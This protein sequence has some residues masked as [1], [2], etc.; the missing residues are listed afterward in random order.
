MNSSSD[1][2]IVQYMHGFIALMTD[3]ET[4]T[5]R[6]DSSGKLTSVRNMDFDKCIMDIMDV[7]TLGKAVYKFHCDY[8][9]D[10]DCFEQVYANGKIKYRT[11]YMPASMAE[12]KGISIAN[13]Y[14]PYNAVVTKSGYYDEN[15]EFHLRPE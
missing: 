9:S 13:M 4:L 2:W 7:D 15:G 3:N 6:V 11:D 1:G 5:L 8:L 12:R 10:S 14:R